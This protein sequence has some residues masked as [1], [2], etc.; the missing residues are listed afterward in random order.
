[1]ILFNLGLLLAAI[2]SGAVLTNNKM[3]KLS[4]TSALVLHRLGNGFYASLTCSKYFESLDFGNAKEMIAAHDQVWPHFDE[5]IKNRKFCIQ[6]LIQKCVD[7]INGPLQIVSLGAGLD[8]L[9]LNWV[10]LY[11]AIHGF[12]VDAEQ[13]A[14][15]MLAIEKI[16]PHLKGR[17]QCL[18]TDL[19]KSD[20][21][22]KEMKNSGWSKQK[23]SIVVI[24][25][26]SY[27]IS[28][29][30][31]ENVLMVYKQIYSL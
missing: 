15:K 24:E 23:P 18:T 27:Y 17:I 29:S 12:D 1:M 10:D 7:E 16:A 22:A 13:M 2:L 19:S 9:C 30:D 11:P 26:L 20:E 4:S 21:L 5:A 25:G 3:L 28:Q 6:S 31:L 14:E 8:P